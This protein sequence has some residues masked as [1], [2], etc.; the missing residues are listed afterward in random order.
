MEKTNKGKETLQ[1]LNESHFSDYYFEIKEQ[2]DAADKAFDLKPN[3]KTASKLN[4][5]R[6]KF[7]HMGR[8]LKYTE[9]YNREW[10]I[11]RDEADHMAL[12]RIEHLMNVVGIETAAENNKISDSTRV[13]LHTINDKE[14]PYN[15]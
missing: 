15:D 14:N 6:K 10:K 3:T 5:L 7:E 2:F 8:D 1:L 13:L 11:A 9:E 4:D 12:Q